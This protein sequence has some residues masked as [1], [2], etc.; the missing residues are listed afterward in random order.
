M[1]AQI[2]RKALNRAT[3]ARQLL[4]ERSDM[5]VLDAL[6]H[7]VGLQAQTTH[8]W[9]HGLWSRLR[10]F[11][12]RELSDL[13]ANREVVRMVLMRSTIHL[14]TAR[15]SLALRPLLQ[16]VSERS[17]MSVYGK[18][19]AGL[20]Q[21][22]LVAEGRKLLDEKPMTF[23]ELGKRMAERWPGHDE[24]SLAYAVRAWVPLV[25]VPPRGL[26]GRSGLAAHATVETWLGAQV[27]AEPDID[28]LVLRYL[29][30]FGPASVKD[31]QTWSGLTRLSEVFARL[32]PKLVTFEDENGRELFDLPDAPR[33]AESTPAPP[34]YLYDFDNLLLSHHDRSRIVVDFA[35]PRPRNGMLPKLFLVDGFTAGWWTVEKDKDR[36]VL[37]VHP[38]RNLLK[39]EVAALT[40][41]GLPLLEFAAPGCAHDIRF[42]C[43]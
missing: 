6:E 28:R 4:L 41:E 24:Q 5:P 27:D 10:T 14:V 8:S 35:Q 25:Q 43:S 32:R 7:L 39:K 20:D 11:D 36:A 2:S 40:K 19:I 37:V 42:E 30:A 3:L 13:L 12:P 26:W 23:T 29:A 33:P 16:I 17:T 38:Y 15:D 22:G 31:A 34:R 21:A 9:Y 18:G 1:T